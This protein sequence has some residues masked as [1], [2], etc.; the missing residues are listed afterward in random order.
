MS[1]ST[2]YRLSNA[3]DDEGGSDNNGNNDMSIIKHLNKDI[4]DGTR[5]EY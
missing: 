5:L 4:F 2:E 1:S 3:S